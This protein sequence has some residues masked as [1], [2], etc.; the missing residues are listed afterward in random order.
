[1]GRALRTRSLAPT[2]APARAIRPN[3]SRYFS[4]TGSRS[5]NPR[6]ARVATRREAVALCTP[7]LR[8]S[9]VTP[10]SPDSEISSSARNA[11]RTDWRFAPGWSRIP[12]HLGA[13]PQQRRRMVRRCAWLVDTGRPRTLR[14]AHPSHRPAAPYALPCR[15]MSEVPAT[16]VQPNRST[17][18]TSS[19][20]VPAVTASRPPTTSP[21]TTASPTSASSRRAGSAAATWPATPRSSVPTTSGTNRPRSTNTP[22]SSGKASR[23]R[24]PSTCSSPSEA[25]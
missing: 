11:R 15:A 13:C 2:A 12:Q 5:T 25:C 17:P 16:G 4:V 21:P 7:S 8:P 18:T 9:S 14:S 20:W 24:W 1:M 19:S 22:S 6:S 10:H 3:P 23:K